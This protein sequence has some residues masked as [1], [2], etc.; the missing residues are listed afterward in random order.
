MS[1]AALIGLIGNAALLLALGVVYDAIFPDSEKSDTGFK[2]VLAGVVVGLIGMALMLSSWVLMSGAIFDARSVL[3]SVSG[4]FFGP[5][6]TGVAVVISGLFQIYQGGLG[7]WMGVTVIVVTAGLGVAWRYG[8][9]RTRKKLDWPE[10]YIFGV[11]VHVVML[12]CMLTLPWPAALDV[13]SKISLPVLLVYPA[14]TVLMGML[15]SHQIERRTVGAALKESEEKF[16]CYVERAPLGVFIADRAGRYVEVNSAAARMLGYTETELLDLSIPDMLAPESLEAGQQHFAAVVE[17]GNASGEMPLRRKEGSP[18]WMSV[19]AVRLSDDRFIAFCQDITK[20]KQAEV[21]MREQVRLQEQLA[22]IAATVPG[23]ICSFQLKPD[24]SACFPYASPVIQDLYGLA[25]EELARGAA[26]LWAMIH[27]DDLGHLNE[28]IAE[29]AR[30]LT[31]WHDEFRVL[32]P[33]EG[34]IWIEGR[35]VPERLPDGGTLW[36]GFIMDITDRKHAENQIRGVNAELENR[37]RQR[38]A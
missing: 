27:P 26:P 29:S 5:L 32:H 14:A 17:R 36:H 37:V 18:V 13:L 24:G 28:L 25:P 23:V 4:L 16:R 30:T 11:V 8:R 34:E 3:L 31:L 1:Y 38:T 33:V 21:T 9:R 12:L 22:K 35:S 2:Q 10:L 19:E 7:A 20:R 6:T 15:L